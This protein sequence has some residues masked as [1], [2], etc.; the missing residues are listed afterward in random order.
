MNLDQARSVVVQEA[1][2]LLA[3]MDA[4]LLQLENHGY[5]TEHI[6]AVFRAV[7]TIKGSAGLFALDNLVSF[8]HTL[9]SVLEQVRGGDVP[10]DVHLLPLLLAGGDYIASMVN[11]VEQRREHNDPDPV[12]RERLLNQL[13]QYLINPTVELLPAPPAAHSPAGSDEQPR[14]HISLRPSPDVLRKGLEPIHFIRYLGELGRIVHVHTL[15]KSIPQGADFDPQQNYLGYEI[16]FE[17]EAGL[18]A[19][20][21]VFEFIREHCQLRIVP[22]HSPLQAYRELIESLPEDADYLLNVLIASGALNADEAAQVR[23]PPVVPVVA[24][25]PDVIASV[26][27]IKPGLGSAEQRFIK[28]EVSKLDELI[29]LVGELVIAEAAAR[30]ARLG[31]DQARYEAAEVVSAL[32]EDIR[33]VSLALRMVAIGEVFQRFP[34]VVRDLSREMGKNIALQITG[35]ETEL[36]KSMVEKLTD[37][38]MHLVRNAIDHGVEPVSERLAA[39]KPARSLLRL[40]AYQESGSVVIEVSDDG[41][42]LDRERIFA[43]AL[44]KGLLEPDQAVTDQDVFELIFHAGLSTADAVSNLSGRGVGMD[45]VRTN[46]EKLRGD[47]EVSSQPRQG[48]T[49]KVRLPLTLAIIAGF[50]V[51]VA[52]EAFVLPLDQV[53]ECVD[54]STQVRGHDLLDLRGEGLPFVRLRSLFGKPAP[55]GVRESLLVVQYGSNRAGIVVDQLVGELQAVIKP[56]GQLFAQ[57]AFLSGSTILGN[58]SVALILDVAQLIKRANAMADGLAQPT[59]RAR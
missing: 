46:I 38:L 29:N 24:M 48:T 33:D 12:T 43:R 5:D 14:W 3:E 57:N 18:E 32:V 17:T 19:V 4:A 13:N 25:V 20:E 35:A 51:Q 40:N 11:E 55:E 42:G 23:V 16:E 1:R 53:V 10:L 49:V 26:D 27:Q 58:G 50:Q 28:V 2:E 31:G 54:L 41:R 6:N 8:C 22:P 36:D 44:E 7:H 45:V 30:P 15:T 56:L 59:D 39:G 34:R 9:E 21:G 47:V 37:P 52:G